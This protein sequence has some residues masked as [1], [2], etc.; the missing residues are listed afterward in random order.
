MADLPEESFIHG[1]YIARLVKPGT[2]HVS[3]CDDVFSF[4]GLWDISKRGDRMVCSLFVIR[5]FVFE[6]KLW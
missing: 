4:D 5:D 2:D 6:Y 1:V 3:N